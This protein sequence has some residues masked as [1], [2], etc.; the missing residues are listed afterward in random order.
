M[1]N[2]DGSRT[3]EEDADIARQLEH[4]KLRK[5]TPEV[6]TKRLEIKIDSEKSTL[7]EAIKGEQS[8]KEEAEFHKKK[9]ELY[10]KFNDVRFLEAEDKSQLAEM[11]TDIVNEASLIK[12]QEQQR[13]QSQN[14]GN[15]N[16][17]GAPLNSQQYGKKETSFEDVPSMIKYLREN[18]SPTNEA[19]L[20]KLFQ[21][22]VQGIKQ[23]AEVD[24]SQVNPKV[25]TRENA[26]AK[27][28][29]M[30]IENAGNDPS[31]ESELAKFGIWFFFL[32]LIFSS[33][34]SIC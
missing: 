4:N 32:S 13:R 21:K 1:P 12:K 23:G 34:S 7:S 27:V 19:I 10:Q 3:P 26:N 14:S 17:E 20:K 5:R 29:E 11:V 25:E 22:A 24:F 18:P 30:P 15:Q 33:C 6:E 31:Q 8:A 9:I 28:I 16:Y 2:E